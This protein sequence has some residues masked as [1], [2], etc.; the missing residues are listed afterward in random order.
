MLSEELQKT[1]NLAYLEA[2][3]RRHA[4]LTLEHLLYALLEND[5]IQKIFSACGGHIDQL[6]KDLDEFLNEELQALDERENTSIQT[7]LAVQRTLQRAIF[8]V[9][10]SG[11]RSVYPAN[12]FVALFG[13]KDSHAVY[14]LS[15][16]EVSRLDVVSYLSH[17]VSKMPSTYSDSASGLNSKAGEV[18]QSEKPLEAYAVNLN[19]KAF[20]GKIDPLIGRDKE[21]ERTIQVLCRRRKNNPLYVGD[22]GVGKTALA[23]GLALRIFEKKVP[24][25]L[26]D[27]IIFSLDLGSLL[28]GTKFRGD[29]EQRLKLVLQEL[30]KIPHAILFIDE[31]HTIVGAGATTGGTMDASNLLKPALQ[32]GELKCIGSTTY[33][34]FKVIE[35]DRALHRRFQKIDVPEPSVEETI[36]ILEGLKEKLETHHGITYSQG[37]IE[38]AATLSHKHLHERFL[39]DKA[40]DVL[41]EAGSAE[42]LKDKS[43]RKQV[44][45]VEEIQALVSKIAR[46]PPQTVSLSDKEKLKN[47]QHELQRTLFGQEEA[48]DKVTQAIKLSRSGLRD[49]EKPIASFLFTGPTG[50]GKTELSKELARILGIEFLRFDMSEYSEKHTISRLIGAPPGYVG[51]DQGGLLTDE[52]RKKPHA[53]LLLDEIEK[54]HPDLFNILLQVMDYGKLTDNNGKKADFSNI[55]LIMTSNAGS[56][57]MSRQSIGIG[58]DHKPYH[59]PKL[60]KDSFSPEF[61]NRLDSVVAFKPLEP[62]HIHKVAEKFIA[63]LELPLLEKG[64]EIEL[65]EKVYSYLVQHGYDQQNGARPMKRLIQEKIKRVLADEILFGRLEKGGIVK[66]EVKDDDLEFFYETNHPSLEKSSETQEVVSMD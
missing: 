53:V 40:I 17:G 21:I 4:Y 35:K 15:K 5:E 45:G 27:A 65:D 18:P 16:Q 59:D 55:I 25:V 48:I 26:K 50:V 44:I 58:R 52:I 47:L 29:F 30:K 1:L 24:E 36:K 46:I 31:I 7:S 60:I 49:G 37:A 6:K 38:A 34:E 23:E 22:P 28:A 3:N 14:Y 9:Q 8:H 57:E 62:E 41:D 13:E 64:V 33:E 10:S 63:E 39:P 2:K 19:Q 51:F 32:S 42:R 61:L 66:I 20:E 43:L 11:K 54:A 12:V 56:R